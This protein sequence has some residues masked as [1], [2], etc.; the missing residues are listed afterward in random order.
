MCL[1]TLPPIRTCLWPISSFAQFQ[2]P[3]HNTITCVLLATDSATFSDFT[4]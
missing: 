4:F 1:V 2:D 3:K